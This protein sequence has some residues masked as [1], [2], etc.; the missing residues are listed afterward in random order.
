MKRNELM[1]VTDENRIIIFHTE[2]AELFDRPRN[3]ANTPCL[4]YK[5]EERLKV[6]GWLHRVKDWRT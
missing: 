3:F 5:F 4:S 6:P 2:N 1:L